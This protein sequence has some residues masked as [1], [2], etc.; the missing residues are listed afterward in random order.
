MKIVINF[1]PNYVDIKRIFPK[2]EEHKA[3]FCWGDTVFNPFN[4]K[5]NRDLEIHEAV[6]SKQQGEKPDEWW[7]K[8]IENKAFRL[9]QEIE[10]YGVQLYYLKQNLPEKVSKWFL[11]KISE[12]LS[13]DLYGNILTTPQA[14]SKLRHF[15]KTI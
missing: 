3:V 12:T 4:V 10:A 2:C 6:H 11:G 5:I 13:G 14:E 9:Q 1:P 15:I 7:K 8:Y